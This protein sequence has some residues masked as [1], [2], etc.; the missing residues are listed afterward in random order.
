MPRFKSII[1]YQYCPKT[2]LFLKK[3]AK[4]S[5]AGAP[6]PRPPTQPSS[7][8]IS[9]YVPAALCTVYNHMGFRSFCFEQFFLHRSVANLMML[10]VID[11]CLIVFCLKSLI[12]ITRCVT[13]TSSCYITLSYLY[14]KV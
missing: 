11:V 2:K 12:C 5:S 14:A 8:Q 9:G 7:L 6:P 10:T 13:L 3:N 4:F 1:F